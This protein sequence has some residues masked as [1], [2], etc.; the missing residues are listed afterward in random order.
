MAARTS[1]ARSTSMILRVEGYIM[2]Y[3]PVLKTAKLSLSK[4]QHLA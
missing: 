4:I 3:K 2:Y 1:T